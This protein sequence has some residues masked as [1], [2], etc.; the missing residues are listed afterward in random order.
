MVLIEVYINN[1]L[2]NDSFGWAEGI[3]ITDI[4]ITV[5][6]GIWIGIS[7]NRNFTNN[8]AIKEY[9][10]TESQSIRKDYLS[11]LNCLY[12]E[13]GSSRLIIE[14]FKIMT[15]KID[16]FEKYLKDEFKVD[17][18]ILTI[19][20]GLKKFITDSEE[21]NAHYSQEV[22]KFSPLNKKRIIEESARFSN[23]LTRI[24][25]EINRAGKNNH[26]RKRR[27]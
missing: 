2:T 24:V 21:L 19:H 20:N 4:L 18:Q 5:S 26:W 1:P 22:I 16:V 7:V 25:I 14:W 15:I 3:A 10:I 6:L 27:R 23:E 11:F 17:P 8:R 12:K 13:K 9:F